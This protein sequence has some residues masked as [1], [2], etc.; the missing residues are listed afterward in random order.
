[1]SAKLAPQITLVINGQ[2]REAECPVCKDRLRLPEQLGSMQDQ[3]AQLQGIFEGHL[4]RWHA[5]VWNALRKKSLQRI[6]DAHRG[7]LW[8]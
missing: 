3:L 2:I 1:V 6:G 4:R 8:G 7:M 5:D